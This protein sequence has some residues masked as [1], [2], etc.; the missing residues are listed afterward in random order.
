MSVKMSGWVMGVRYEIIPTADGFTWRYP[1]DWGTR[2]GFATTAR[3]ARRAAKR[4]L[5]LRYG[6]L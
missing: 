2:H 4:S 3:K 6:W 5:R 1:T